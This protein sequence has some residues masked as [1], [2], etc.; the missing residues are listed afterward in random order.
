MATNSPI[1]W[2]DATWNPVTG[3]D[4]ISPGCKHCYAERLAHRLQAMGNKNYRNGF[5]LTLQPHML[6][7]PVSWKSPKRIFVNSMSDLF[8]DKV[9]FEYIKRVFGVM[10]Q[11]DWHQYQILTK[12]AERL[13]E[14]SNRLDW[15]PHIWMGVSVE[16]E[17][18][19]SRIDHLRRTQA[20]VKFLS[21]EPL[22]GPLGR[23][24]L[25]GVDWVIVGGESGPG[26]RT[27]ESS[28]VESV[29]DQCLRANVAF[30]FKQWGGVQKSKT[31]RKLEG[32]TWDEMP[33]I[34]GLVELS[35]R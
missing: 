5:E 28:W 22:L 20:H 17:K 30:F 31:G 18:Y 35:T 3:C 19:L 14:L 26:A 23:I 2:T 29:R 24:D 1:E 8:H 27:M 4:K 11:A 15:S 16:S 9:P 34:T 21:I 13:E 10:N 32:R 25:R 7:H 6:Q 33:T 12:R